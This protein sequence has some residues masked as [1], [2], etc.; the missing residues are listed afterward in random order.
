MEPGG[1]EP[2]PCSATYQLPDLG[3]LLLILWASIS[4]SENWG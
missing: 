3:Q 4:S 2:G 1:W